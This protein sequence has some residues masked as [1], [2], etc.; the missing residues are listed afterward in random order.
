MIIYR[1][2]SLLLWRYTWCI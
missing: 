2:E 1:T